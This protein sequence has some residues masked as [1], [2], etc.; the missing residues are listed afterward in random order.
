[1]GVTRSVRV[2][3]A[4]ALTLAVAL[5]AGCGVAPWN[6]DSS[7]SP[8][9]STAT[10]VPTPIS[11]DLST[12]STERTVTAGSVTAT[13]NYW[14]TLSMDLWTPTA[15]KPISLSLS[16]TVTPDDGQKVYL[17]TAT[18]V[19]VPGNSSGALSP[20]DA[21]TDTYSV[22]SSGAPGY[23]VLSPYSYS[24]TFNIG[25]VP[26]ESTYVTVQL[27]YDFLVQTT[28]TSSEYAKQTASDTL[29]VLINSAG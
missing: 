14:S 21:Q 20:L 23:L 22:P 7:A 3:A 10:A 29:V 17:Q 16:T 4:T 26:A 25:E 12:G 6:D 28:P 24:Q 9:T 11:N 5:L 13:I 1:M 18:M 2:G 8:T 19:V 15:L 27:T